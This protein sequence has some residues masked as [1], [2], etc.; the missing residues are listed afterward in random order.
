MAYN[1]VTTTAIGRVATDINVRTTAQGKNVANFRLVTQE[2]RFDK[3][4]NLWLDGERMF[5]TVSCWGWMATNVQ[6]SL[7]KGDP[8][9]VS[10]R[11]TLREYKAD[12]GEERVSLDLTARA[13]GPDLSACTATIT[14]PARDTATEEPLPLPMPAA[15]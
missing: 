15:A 7:S 6:R 12:S 4:T 14:R 11:L 10:G 5:F 8:V 3:D 13:I 9:V 2:R 1:E